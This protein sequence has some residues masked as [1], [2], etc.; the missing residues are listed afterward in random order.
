MP[1]TK[2]FKRTNVV[3]F[4]KLSVAVFLGVS[5]PAAVVLQLLLLRARESLLYV[6]S[7]WE[8]WMD[9]KMHRFPTNPNITYAEIKDDKDYPEWNPS[10]L[11]ELLESTTT[12]C[13]RLKNI[14][15]ELKCKDCQTC[16]IDGNKY[17]CFDDD[18][19]PI[20]KNCLI[21]SFGV[22]GDTSWDEAMVEL[23]CSVYAFDMT[24]IW[25]NTMFM[26]NFHFLDIQLSHENTDSKLNLTSGDDP[27]KKPLVV[28]IF[29]RSLETIR[30][31]LGHQHRI[32]DILKMD[33]EY[34]EWH[35]FEDIFSCPEK[36]KILDD[37]KQIALEVS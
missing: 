2:Q 19:R 29:M 13:R 16:K 14:G 3:T 15:G 8:E 20:P 1:S 31:F 25:D 35:I 24:T 5:L 28:D 32:I 11:V 21:Y 17:V 7:P 23:N 12:I 30:D 9:N 37:V 33:I 26:E 10:H 36:A 4:L 6:W 27:S 22:G 34:S 18:V